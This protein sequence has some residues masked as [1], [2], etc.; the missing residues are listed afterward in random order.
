MR[1]QQGAE[2]LMFNRLVS[3]LPLSFQIHLDAEVIC[4]SHLVFWFTLFSAAFSFC[5]MSKQFIIEVESLNTDLQ[6]CEPGSLVRHTEVSSHL[7]FIVI[8]SWLPICDTQIPGTNSMISFVNFMQRNM[9]NV[10]ALLN[11]ALQTIFLSV[12][13]W[14]FVAVSM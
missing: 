8:A 6:N 3:A 1:V 14:S 9:C 12:R 10:L 13:V 4:D 11:H 2:V 7:V 5:T